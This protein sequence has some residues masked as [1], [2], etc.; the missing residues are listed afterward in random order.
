MQPWEMANAEELTALG[1]PIPNGIRAMIPSGGVTGGSLRGRLGVPKMLPVPAVNP[2]NLPAVR[3]NT[4]PV[5]NM[6]RGW[7]TGPINPMGPGGRVPVTSAPLQIG[8]TPP[9]PATVSPL[10]LGFKP[11]AIR[12]GIEGMG[13]FAPYATN[14]VA[15]TGMLRSGI[16][17]IGRGLTHPLVA[18]ASVL[19]PLAGATGDMERKSGLGY[20]R[21]IN[22][23][24]EMQGGPISTLGISNTNPFTGLPVTNYEQQ[25][26][27]MS[28]YVGK[29]APLT[30]P[31]NYGAMKDAWLKADQADNTPVA[32][33]TA[34]P[35]GFAIVDGNK[36]NYGDIGNPLKDAALI[37]ST[38]NSFAINPATAGGGNQVM[39][40]SGQ[41]GLGNI[42]ETIKGIAPV[43]DYASRVGAL[44]SGN[45]TW[46]M[47]DIAKV[48]AA[49]AG[50]RADEARQVNQYGALGHLGSALMTAEAAKAGHAMA[51]QG[52]REKNAYMAPFYKQYGDYHEAQASALPTHT[53]A[54]VIKALAEQAKS[55]PGLTASLKVLEGTIPG[56]PQYNQ[57]VS[58][59]QKMYGVAVPPV[60]LEG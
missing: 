49:T 27:D 37:N 6:N 35:H 16:G 50:Q 19:G 53:K 28:T 31:G 55:N 14:G 45:T 18:A 44:N 20:Q 48:R 58:Q 52:E 15:K 10:Q 9:S 22:K 26:A 36:I 21:G 51:L 13:D 46:D 23:S 41:G 3:G 4:L 42:L 25:P 39:G 7:S 43:Q 54:E 1:K 29:A 60:N 56:T 30:L 38:G 57:L 2:Q 24:S 33:I 5:P 11:Q 40:D 32:P 8:F 12:A 47:G 17:A 34:D 59:I